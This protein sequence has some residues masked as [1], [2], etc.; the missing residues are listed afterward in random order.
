MKRVL[1]TGATGAIG[2]RV[3]HALH[4]TGCAVRTFSMN[5][6]TK[7]VFPEEVE[8]LIGDV[9]DPPA[10][11]SAMQD[12]DSV[13][14]MAA[15]LHIVNPPPGL[16]RKYEHI[17]VGGTETMVE[18]AIKAN[19]R[20]IV[21]FSTVA[22]YGTPEGQVLDETSPTYPDTFYAQT[23]LAAEEIVLSAQRVDGQRIGTVLRLAAVYGS[24]IKGNYRRLVQSLA[25]GR[26]IPVGNALNWRT[27]IYD[28]DVARAAAL[29]VSHPEAAGR[30]YNVTDGEFHTVQD[31]IGA[32]CAALG[33]TPPRLCLPLASIR[34]GVGLAENTFRVIGLR[35]PIVRATIDKYTEDIAVRGERI[36]SELGF[37]PGYRLDSGWQ[38]TVAEMHQQGDL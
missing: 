1:I 35:P 12:V 18:T 38:E 29:A 10:V 2:P 5:A 14:H 3:V 34:F 30:V 15:L 23:K 25:R 9:N 24:R 36:C 11:R 22:V 17:N 26:F 31:V 28:K 27:L 20:R 4:E 7:G 8:I 33:R 21:L 37:K 32:I 13:I 6:P 19:V 16:Q